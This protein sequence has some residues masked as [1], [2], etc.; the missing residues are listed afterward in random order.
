MPPLRDSRGRFTTAGRLSGVWSFINTGVAALVR[1][2]GNRR[3]NNCAELVVGYI[4]EKMLEPKTGRIYRI[5]GTSETYQ[6]SAPGEY[7]A[8]R[9]GDLWTSLTAQQTGPTEFTFGTSIEYAKYLEGNSTEPG[10]RPF[11]EK[12]VSEAEHLVKQ[13][14]TRPWQLGAR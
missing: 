5:P 12:T 7:P 1:E 2:E 14:M 10:I 4:R 6:A 9:T 8:V 13:E 11:I 3:L